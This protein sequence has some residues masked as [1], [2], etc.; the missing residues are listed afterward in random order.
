MA[1][2]SPGRPVRTGALLVIVAA[3]ALLGL[4][5]LLRDHV[6]AGVLE[7]VAAAFFMAMV[8]FFSRRA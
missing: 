1:R 2:N 6:A 7:L 3:L 4:F 5:S 8:W